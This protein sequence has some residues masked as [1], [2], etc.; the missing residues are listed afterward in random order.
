[1]RTARG[2]RSVPAA[3][4]KRPS[5]RMPRVRR[6]RLIDHDVANFA[7]EDRHGARGRRGAGVRP[8]DT[9]RIGPTSGGVV[10]VLDPAREPGD[11]AAHLRMLMDGLIE[12]HT[13]VQG[14][15]DTEPVPHAEGGSARCQA[16]RPSSCRRGPDDR[17]ASRH[18]VPARIE[19]HG[20]DGR[21]ARGASGGASDREARTI[22]PSTA[23]INWT[24]TK[25]RPGMRALATTGTKRR[26]VCGS[27]IAVLTPN[28]R[29]GPSAQTKKNPATQKYVRPSSVKRADHNPR[30]AHQRRDPIQAA[31][32]TRSI[33]R[34][35]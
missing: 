12:E 11:E 32:S 24:T 21:A 16:A 23:I 1:M 35:S 14:A 25:A 30:R 17:P 5:P 13:M 27:I 19:D 4:G 9:L 33:D 6:F 3:A 29:R 34:R 18:A 7:G 15:A 26:R 31:L 10:R 2:G 8:S 28:T 20:R 22:A